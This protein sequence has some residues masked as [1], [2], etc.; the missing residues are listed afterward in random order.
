MHEVCL[1]DWL[2][3]NNRTTEKCEVCGT[4]FKF[5]KVYRQVPSHLPASL[6]LKQIARTA[7]WALTWVLRCL[8]V[9]VCWT[10]A[11]PWA[12]REFA[13]L[14]LDWLLPVR[15]H[16]NACT[17]WTFRFFF[18]SGS[19]FVY[20]LT[21]FKPR[22]SPAS[23][24]ASSASTSERQRMLSEVLEKA[25]SKGGYSFTV[26]HSGDKNETTIDMSG[27][28]N[29]TDSSWGN[30]LWQYVHGSSFYF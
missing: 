10:A 14:N 22:P 26:Q 16:G 4:P 7:L 18:Y 8:L 1:F 19:S 5:Q 17:V 20:V 25:L 2:T 12:T 6:V 21:G 27:Q 23:E 3:V 30:Y 29:G 24:H 9:V 11:L 15:A 13:A 28:H